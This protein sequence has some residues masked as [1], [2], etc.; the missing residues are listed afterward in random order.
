[1]NKT[2]IVVGSDGSAGSVAAVRWAAT[3]AL[4][5]GAELRVL[6]AY[7]RK[8]T[9]GEDEPAAVVH[10]AV[11]HARSAAP[12]VEMSCLAMHGYAVPM[13]LHAAEEAAMLVLG[14]RRAGRFPGLP[15]GSVSN[16]VATQAQCCVVVVRGRF[17]A[18]TGPV[19]AGVD[20]DPENAVLGRAFEEAALRGAPVLALTAQTGGRPLS[21]AGFDAWRGKYPQVTAESEVVA[22]RPDKVLVQR[23][24]DAQ[25]V[26]VSPRR[27]GYEGVML[28]P[29]GSRLL[30]RADCPVLIAR[31]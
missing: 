5:R 9:G 3:E 8:P 4:R 21:M 25:L 20:E 19:L 7:H 27:H 14:D 1:M 24:R 30:E 10:D 12:D 31:G 17:D 11:A 2:R 18:D 28:G 22:G 29:V 16:Q 15:T 6:T 13:L 26:V 23:S